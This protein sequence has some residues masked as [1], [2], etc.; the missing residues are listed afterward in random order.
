MKLIGSPKTFHQKIC[1]CEAKFG[2]INYTF[3]KM[4]KAA[5]IGAIEGVVRSQFCGLF[6][7]ATS[8]EIFTTDD[9]VYA[10][11]NFVAKNRA[12]YQKERDSDFRKQKAH[13]PEKLKMT[14]LES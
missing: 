2:A 1:L 6:T 10:V 7:D 4:G 11:L 9:H 14:R 5:K 8:K 3:R 12:R 13:K